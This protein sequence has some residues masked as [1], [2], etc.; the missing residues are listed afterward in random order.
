MALRYGRRSINND[1]P[2]QLASVRPFE[3]IAC[4][5]NLEYD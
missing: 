4:R 5:V 3:A 1:L 2:L